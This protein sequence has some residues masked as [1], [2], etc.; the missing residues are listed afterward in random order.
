M[1]YITKLNQIKSNFQKENKIFTLKRNINIVNDKNSI[2]PFKS[3]DIY[4]TKNFYT[5]DTLSNRKRVYNLGKIGKYF[6]TKK[7]KNN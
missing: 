3:S 5:I 7:Y 2:F 4:K 1:N 6:S